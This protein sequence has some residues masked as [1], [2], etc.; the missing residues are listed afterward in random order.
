MR[1]ALPFA[2]CVLALCLGG[3]KEK[4]ELRA[5]CGAPKVGERQFEVPAIAGAAGRLRQAEESEEIAADLDRRRLGAIK[6]RQ[7]M[8]DEIGVERAEAEAMSLDD[9]DAR[10]KAIL[11]VTAKEMEAQKVAEETTRYELDIER[12]LVTARRHRE[13]GREALAPLLAAHGLTDAC[14]ALITGPPPPKPAGAP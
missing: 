9:K 8:Y 1:R 14:R 10:R 12:N 5:L 3:C 7:A 2:L 11:E 4:S 6:R 13:A